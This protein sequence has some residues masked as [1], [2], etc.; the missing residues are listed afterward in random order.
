MKCGRDCIVY[1]FFQCLGI[2]K[3]GILFTLLQV[4][5]WMGSSEGHTVEGSHAAPRD[6]IQTV[7]AVLWMWLILGPTKK[8]VFPTVIRF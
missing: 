3:N 2:S 8:E 6:S 7:I 4:I 1:L 5:Y